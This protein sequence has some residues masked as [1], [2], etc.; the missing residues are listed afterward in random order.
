MRDLQ[1][2][3]AKLEQIGPQG[4]AHIIVVHQG[5]TS[6]EAQQ[7]Y[8]E[9]YPEGSKAKLIYIDWPI[10]EPDLLPAAFS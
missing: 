7:R 6:E 2:R 8:V 10:P 9:H 3:I 5:Q 1:K 4:K